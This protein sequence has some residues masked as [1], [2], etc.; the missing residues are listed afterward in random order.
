MGAGS[1]WVGVWVRWCETHMYKF[2]FLYHTH[3]EIG[4]LTMNNPQFAKVKGSPIQ[5]P[6][7]SIWALPFRGGLKACQ[8][9]LG[10][11]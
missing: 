9:G 11:Y 4:A 8:D 10:T 6:A 1:G 3:I 5:I 2:V 7:G